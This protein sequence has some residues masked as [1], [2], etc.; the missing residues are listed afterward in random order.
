[1]IH[2]GTAIKGYATIS[3]HFRDPARGFGGALALDHHA[4][5]WA[6]TRGYRR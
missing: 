5:T 3:H 2:A 4:G 6:A 1:M